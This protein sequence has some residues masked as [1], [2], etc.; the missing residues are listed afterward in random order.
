MATKNNVQDT[1]DVCCRI[2]KLFYG[3][4]YSVYLRD[5]QRHLFSTNVR[6]SPVHLDSLSKMRVKLAV[7]VLNSKVRKD[8]EKFES[9]STISTQIFIYNCQKLWGVFNDDK[10]LS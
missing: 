2:P 5:K 9:D 8:M 1:H 4:I 7:Q 3:N 10:R 6:S